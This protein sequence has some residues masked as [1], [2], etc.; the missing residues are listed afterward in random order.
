MQALQYYAQALEIILEVGDR[1]V[2]GDLLESLGIAHQ[3]QGDYPQALEYYDEP[4]GVA[5]EI[6][7]R[8]GEAAI[9]N[10]VGAIQ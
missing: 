9:L 6:E 4:I 7:N 3:A 8:S 1:K 2:E 5:R 10:N